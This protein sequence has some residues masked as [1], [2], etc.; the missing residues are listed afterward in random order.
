MRVQVQKARGHHMKAQISFLTQALHLLLVPFSIQLYKKLSINRLQY[1]GIA[2]SKQQHNGIWP[3]VKTH[4][5]QNCM[6]NLCLGCSRGKMCGLHL[7][8][9]R[10]YLHH[11]APYVPLPC[12]CWG[13]FLAH[14]QSS[15]ITVV[16]VISCYANNC[17]VAINNLAMPLVFTTCWEYQIDRPSYRHAK[18]VT[19]PFLAGRCMCFAQD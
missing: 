1:K 2:S 12:C 13:V 10:V 18:F 14:V 16:I 7:G 15:F 17:Y 9:K 8:T 4:E 19:R 6:H 11:A 5:P 3:K